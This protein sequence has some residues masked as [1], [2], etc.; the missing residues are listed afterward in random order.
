MRSFSTTKDFQNHQHD[1]RLEG[2]NI[3]KK[4]PDLIHMSPN[5]SDTIRKIAF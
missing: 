4:A 3:K 5:S 1:P 2:S